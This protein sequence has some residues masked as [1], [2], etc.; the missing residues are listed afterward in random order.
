MI[1]K[2][3]IEGR[4][5]LAQLAKAKPVVENSADALSN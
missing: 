2:A 4:A 1:E 5:P 3:I